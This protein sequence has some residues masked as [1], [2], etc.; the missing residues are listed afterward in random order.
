M[1]LTLGMRTRSRSQAV[2]G[3]M[4]G[5]QQKEIENVRVPVPAQGINVLMAGG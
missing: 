5:P 2:V 4:R 1:G 3:C